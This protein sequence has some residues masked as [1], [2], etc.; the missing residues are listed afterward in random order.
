MV[1]KDRPHGFDDIKARKAKVAKAL[2]AIRK[3]FPKMNESDKRDYLI[4]LGAGRMLAVLAFD[5]K[6]K[7]EEKEKKGKKGNSK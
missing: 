4:A 3:R 1:I 5:V 7:K 2:A 6:E